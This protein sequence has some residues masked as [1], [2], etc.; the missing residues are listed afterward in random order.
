MDNKDQIID[1]QDK[2]ITDLVTIIASTQAQ[3]LEANTKIK[4][5]NEKRFEVLNIDLELPKE[6]PLPI[7]DNKPDAIPVTKEEIEQINIDYPRVKITEVDSE[8]YVMFDTKRGQK[9]QLS[10]L[11]SKET[12]ITMINN[13]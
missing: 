12:I 8:Y 10:K 2:L 6:I 13:L 4:E 9:I 5:Y 3:L 7:E 11:E 1:G